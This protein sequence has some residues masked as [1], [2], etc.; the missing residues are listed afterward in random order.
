MEGKV[1]KGFRLW[2]TS[3]PS[4]IFP[5]SILVCE[6]CTAWVHGG[7]GGMRGMGCLLQHVLGM[8]DADSL[9]GHSY[10]RSWCT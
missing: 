10:I 1:N 3:Y 2:L 9:E 4:D 8:R 7:H 5:I 6:A